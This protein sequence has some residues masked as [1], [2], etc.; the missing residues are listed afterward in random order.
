MSPTIDIIDGIKI[1]F[2]NGEH[3]PPH[4]H[5]VYNEYEVIIDIEGSNVIAGQMPSKQLKKIYDWLVGN[6]AWAKDLFY[7]FNPE[8]L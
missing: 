3:R 2:Y 5:A 8:L 4:F 1:L 6:S 7:E